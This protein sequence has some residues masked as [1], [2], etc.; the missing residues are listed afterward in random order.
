MD[1]Y[2]RNV[3]AEQKVFKRVSHCHD[4]GFH[5][6]YAAFINMNQ[7]AKPFPQLFK[8]LQLSKRCRV[9]NVAAA[10][11][12]AVEAM[13]AADAAV[14]QGDAPLIEDGED[15]EP[16]E[17]ARDDGGHQIDPA[18]GAGDDQAVQAAPAVPAVPAAPAGQAEGALVVRTMRQEIAEEV[19]A[20]VGSKPFH[21]RMDAMLLEQEEVQR[22]AIALPQAP[23]IFREKYDTQS[24]FTWSLFGFNTLLNS[25]Y[26]NGVKNSETIQAI[27]AGTGVSKM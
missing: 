11:A 6:C 2:M 9:A 18:G 13:E 26:E 20:A 7:H 17:P 1:Y 27:C 22:H 8:L 14:I 23:S 25:F 15:E 16:A 4:W 5:S 10:I 24:D 19:M 3:F 12:E 21:L